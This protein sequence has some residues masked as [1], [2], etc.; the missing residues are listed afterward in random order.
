M[1]QHSMVTETRAAQF[2]L[3]EV[4]ATRSRLHPSV[5]SRLIYT[6]VPSLVGYFAWRMPNPDKVGS[7][8][9]NS[10]EPSQCEEQRHEG[11]PLTLEPCGYSSSG[12]NARANAKSPSVKD[13]I[14]SRCWDKPPA[15][16]ATVGAPHI[17]K[18]VKTRLCSGPAV[19][20]DTSAVS[21]A[22]Q[23]PT[24]RPGG[25]CSVHQRGSK[26]TCGSSTSHKRRM[27]YSRLRRRS[28]K[29]HRRRKKR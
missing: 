25:L 22:K 3:T 23:R 17:A 27:P 8:R 12:P 9:I 16:D 7:E 18:M 14:H 10:H 2:R 20:L 24:F 4:I 26:A 28:M 5:L 11:T 1:G 29:A 21:E 6:F 13:S 19:A 15:L